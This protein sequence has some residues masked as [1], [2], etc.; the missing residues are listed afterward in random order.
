MVVMCQLYKHGSCELCVPTSYH[1][2]SVVVDH[3]QVDT[4]QDFLFVIREGSVL[5]QEAVVPP[6]GHVLGRR[7]RWDPGIG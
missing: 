2:A 6:L 1:V 3:G 4:S 7:R 5:Q